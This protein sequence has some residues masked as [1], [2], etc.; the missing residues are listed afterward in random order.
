MAGE[1]ATAARALCMRGYL[2]TVC[3]SVWMD[4]AHG[5]GVQ[6]I[7]QY[8][9]V[10]QSVTLSV[11]GVTGTIRVFAWYKGSSVDTNNQIFNVIPSLNSVTHGRQYFSRASQ[12]P[13]GS[14]QISGLVPTDQ[15]N[16]TVFIQ[17]AEHTEQHTV[18]LTVYE[19]VTKPVISSSSSQLLINKTLTLTCITAHAERILWR[20]DGN[21]LPTG[22]D[23]SPDNRTVTFHRINRWDA[24]QYQCEAENPI[25]GNMSDI[26]TLTVSYGPENV[27]SLLHVN[28]GS[29]RPS[30]QC[31]ADSVP[32]PTYLWRINGT[33]IPHD[34]ISVLQDKSQEQLVYICEVYN[35]VTRRSATIS[36]HVAIIES[37]CVAST[38]GIISGSFAGTVLIIYT[39]VLLYKKYSLPLRKYQKASLSKRRESIYAS[40][41]KRRESI[42]GEL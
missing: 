13:N 42:Y 39:T 25:S 38:V 3:L 33:V 17:T 37:Y 14:L 26:F 29:D 1:K 10:N 4:S 23:L 8:P 12:F 2:L 5:I 18:L 40:G 22:V 27:K 34:T 24:G 32:A 19:P 36:V 7:P 20:K 28:T 15:G 9:V 21:G 35:S 16:Y 30:L 41:S 11:T 6:L 31:V